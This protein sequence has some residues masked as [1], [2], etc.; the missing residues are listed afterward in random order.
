M[1]EIV[2]VLSTEIALTTA[3]TVSAA[4]VVRVLNNNGGAALITRT[5]SNATVIG[6]LTVNANEV[7]YLQKSPSDTFT[8]NVSV[9]AT[10]ISFSQVSTM[11]LFTELVED[12]QCIVEDVNG[13]KNMF[14]TGPFMQAEQK[15][16]NGRIYKLP[17][18]EREVA[19][20]TKDYINTNRALGELGHP[21]GPSINLDRVCI[22]IVELN[23]SGNDFIGKAKILNTP[24][25]NIAQNLIESGVQLGVSTRGMGSLKTINGIMEVQDDFFL[26]TAADVVADPSAPDA[27]VQ[28][29]MEGVDWVW[30]NGLIKAQQVEQHK[31]IITKASKKGLQ[32]AKLS[33]FEHFLKSIQNKYKYQQSQ[34]Q[35]KFMTKEIYE[36][37]SDVVGG[38][39]TGGSMVADPV[40]GTA[41]LP[42][43]KKQGDPMQSSG[44]GQ[45]TN[46]ENNTAPVGDYADANKQSIAAKTSMKE[47]IDQLFGDELTED[48]KEKALVVFEAAVAGK[49]AEYRDAIQEQ[50]AAEKAALEEAFH[51]ASADILEQVSDH[52][53]KYLDY[54][55]ERWV[56]D[57]QVAIDESLNTQIAEEF[58]GKL[59]A[60]FEESYIQVPADK[61]DVVEEM[62]ARIEQLEGEINAHISENIDLRSAVASSKQNE[63][64][65]Q[66]SEGLTLS[67]VEKLR[68]LSEG[69]SYETEDEYRTKLNIVKDRYFSEK[70]AAVK[71]IEEQEMVELAED[72]QH[73]PA[74]RGP[75]ASY[76][77]AISRTTKK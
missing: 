42:A 65:E 64:F 41:T 63:V 56:E 20:Y 50:Y 35:E 61:I 76:V 60:L 21:S 58:M 36:K 54:V 71:S 3:N 53:G 55:V 45:P 8:S 74:A 39:A 52:V 6:T 16:R 31:Q 27:Y 14:I 37:A 26:A 38:G 33:V 40:G 29:I 23:Q 7:I 5:D 73:T 25:G 67:Q 69:V 19:R 13:K 12:I 72:V 43:S 2:K 46:S 44:G 1:A 10:S 9:R 48:F 49:V 70:V 30:D 18:L 75:V 4:S 32:E 57:N 17:I 34:T 77:S 62:A 15:N 28:G 47:E 68:T 22:K 11:K 59:K 66:V 24:M 51:Q